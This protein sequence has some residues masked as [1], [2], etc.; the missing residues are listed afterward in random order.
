MYY[1]NYSYS[2]QPN[3]RNS[4]IMIILFVLLGLFSS[5]LGDTFKIGLVRDKFLKYSPQDTEIWQ[6]ARYFAYWMNARGGLAYLFFIIFFY[7]NFFYYLCFHLFFN[8]KYAHF[9]FKSIYI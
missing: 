7:L 9:L 2:I 1:Y 8:T 6:G 4:N 3:T 5:T